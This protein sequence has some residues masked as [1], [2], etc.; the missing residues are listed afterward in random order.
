MKAWSLQWI[1]K[2]VNW[3]FVL[4]LICFKCVRCWNWTLVIW[5]LDVREKENNGFCCVYYYFKVA[6]DMLSK[7]WVRFIA[8]IFNVCSGWFCPDWFH[9]FISP[10]ILLLFWGNFSILSFVFH[11]KGFVLLNF[12][13]LKEMVMLMWLHICIKKRGI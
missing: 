12:I 8:V 11:G 1:W 5:P 9:K 2:I 10:F 7:H 6:F 3:R 4:D 13:Q